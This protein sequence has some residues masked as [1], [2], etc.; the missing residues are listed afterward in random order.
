MGLSIKQKI[1]ALLVGGFLYSALLFGIKY[2]S[3][4]ETLSSFDSIRNNEIELMLIAQDIKTTLSRMQNAF[5]VNLTSMVES[6]DMVFEIDSFEPSANRALQNLEDFAQTN[7]IE[8]LIELSKNLNIR[9]HAFSS[10][11]HEILSYDYVNDPEEAL[12][13]IDAINSIADRMNSELD[14]IIDFSKESLNQGVIQ[15]SQN[16]HQKLQNL[17]IISTIAVIIFI[18]IGILFTNDILKRINLLLKGT[19]EF[20]HKNFDYRVEIK[21]DDELGHL[22]S[23]FN[24]MASSIKELLD[25]Q[26]RAN[27]ILD[28]KVKEKTKELSSSLEKIEKA[29]TMIMDSI[30]YAS[31]I[32][33]AFLPKSQKLDSFL[34]DHFVIWHQKDVVGGDFYWAEEREDGFMLA[35][36]DCTGHGVPGSLMTMVAVSALDRI[37]KESSVSDPGKIL[38][39]LH[40]IISDLLFGSSDDCEFSDDGMEVGLCHISKDEKVLTYSGARLPLFYIED[41]EINEVKGNKKGVGYRDTPR[42]YEFTN[43]KIDVKAGMSFYIVTD[44]ITEQVGGQKRRMVY[45]KKRFK[46]FIK[47]VYKKDKSLQ[48]ELLLDNI[49]TYRGSEPQRDDMT[50]LGFKFAA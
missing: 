4:Q 38:S 19:Y 6:G 17:L 22:G 11:A 26:E 39:S 16:I 49:H 7:N 42:D 15:F 2:V 35:V 20:A 29:N 1:I 43:T 8:R 5:I 31:R 34:S 25:E 37:T 41:D 14:L 18:A 28:E 36:I 47:E 50:C 24:E 12:F 30:H 23:S 48:K 40:K 44:G 21:R 33:N 9:Y 46:E 13:G 45:G 27:H 10:N 32:Q 3:S